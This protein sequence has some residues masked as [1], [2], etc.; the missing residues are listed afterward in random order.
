MGVPC[1]G[2]LPEGL[3]GALGWAVAHADVRVVCSLK[4]LP[5]GGRFGERLSGRFGES[6]SRMCGE[7]LSGRFGERLSG[8]CGERLSRMCGESLYG[9]VWQECECVWQKC[10]MHVAKVS[11]GWV[12]RRCK[13]GVTK[14][15]VCGKWGGKRVR[16][17]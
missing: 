3:G 4:Q 17:T 2:G 10:E 11:S 13:M 7:S 8:M 15:C 16:H 12:W 1:E 9:G 14:L 6:L 5:A